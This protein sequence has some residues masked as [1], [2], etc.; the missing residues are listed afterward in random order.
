MVGSLVVDT[1]ARR[2]VVVK[3]FVLQSI[4]LPLRSTDTSTIGCLIAAN[5][6][7]L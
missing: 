7:E 5:L 3:Y 2:V 6:V 1:M 4:D